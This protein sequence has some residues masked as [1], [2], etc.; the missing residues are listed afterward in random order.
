MEQTLTREDE[1]RRGLLVNPGDPNLLTE[2]AGCLIGEERYAEA[3]ETAWILARLMPKSAEAYN[4]LAVTQMMA[5]EYK[6]AYKS[7]LKARKNDPNHVQS[8]KTWIQL[9][10]LTGKDLDEAVVV[11]K[12]LLFNHPDDL[13]VQWLHG[14]CL[15]ATN[16]SEKAIATFQRILEIEPGY[17]L[18][19]MSLD[20]LV[21]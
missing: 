9:A 20:E 15:V 17:A 6:Q 7:I 4:N 13:D 2:L 5:G 18:A 19:Q 14:R 3:V 12:S 10:I 11:L 8:Q 1:I 21:G 16:Q